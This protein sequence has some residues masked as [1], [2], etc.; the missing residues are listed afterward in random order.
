MIKKLDG[1][2]VDKLNT[3]VPLTEDNFNVLEGVVED[4]IAYASDFE[5]PYT[6]ESGKI[7]ASDGDGGAKWVNALNDEN[8]Y[9]KYDIDGKI[10]LLSDLKT[11]AKNNLVESINEIHNNITELD[12]TDSIIE[13]QNKA[14]KLSND[15]K[16]INSKLSSYVSESTFNT[17]INDINNKIDKNYNE[18][19]RKIND[20]DVNTDVS[21][22][23]GD[24]VTVNGKI[25]SLTNKI[26]D[27]E[28]SMNASGIDINII[29]GIGNYSVVQITD[30]DKKSTNDAMGACSSAFG[31]NNVSSGE[32]ASA[33]G[34]G[35]ISNGEYSFIVGQYNDPKEDTTSVFAIGNGTSSTNRKNLLTVSSS[36]VNIHSNKVSVDNEINS[37]LLTSEA[38]NVNNI[39]INNNNGISGQVLTSTGTGV[40]WSTVETST[41]IDLASL[42]G[43]KYNGGTGEIFNN[44]T[45]NKATGDCSHAEGSGTSAN[46]NYSHAGGNNSIAI[47]EGSFVH[48]INLVAGVS[49]KKDSGDY[50]ESTGNF[51]T[52]QTNNQFVVGKNNTSYDGMLFAV[53]NGDSYNSRSNIIDMDSNTIHIRRN[54]DIEGNITGKDINTINSNINA[55]NAEMYDL[56][57]NILKLPGEEGSSGESILDKII[58]AGSQADDALDKSN[59]N[60]ESIVNI[61]K[62]LATIKNNVNT[63]TTNITTNTRDISN[64]QK[65]VNTNTTNIKTNTNKISAL[66]TNIATNTTTIS[67]V[68]TLVVDTVQPAIVANT[69]NISKNATNIAT[70]KANI[71]TNSNNIATNAAA[72]KDIQDSMVTLEKGTGTNAFVQTAENASVKNI[73]SGINSMAL[74]CKSSAIGDY[75]VAVGRYGTAGYSS[76]VTGDH[77][78]ADMYSISSGEYNYSKSYSETSGAY[79]SACNYSNAEGYGTMAVYSPS[80]TIKSISNVTATTFNCSPTISIGFECI[81]YTAN[82]STTSTIV[83]PVIVKVTAVSGTTHTFTNISGGKISSSL[84]MVRYSSTAISNKKTTY[85]HAEGLSSMALGIASH[86][87]GFQ[88]TAA[89]E[90]SH[91]EGYNSS[92][93]A[94]CAH[95]GGRST[96]A[97]NDSMTA[98]GKYN[99]KNDTGLAGT[100][101]SSTIFSIGKGT[102]S[103]KANCFRVTLDG[104]SYG[105]THASSGADY[106]E[107]FE[108]LDGNPDNED[109][110][111]YF[112]T[113][114]GEMIR[115][116]NSADKYILGVVS[117][118]PS[119]IGDS[120][121]DEWQGKYE[122]DEFGR[123][124]YN[125]DSEE[126]TPKLSALF[127]EDTEYIARDL[128]PEWS[129]IGLLGKLYVRQDGTLEV[130]RFCS[131]NDEGIA[132]KADNGYYVMSVD[133]NVAKIIF[134]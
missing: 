35:N 99:T 82:T 34:N 33:F 113:L 52:L 18:L 5:L 85:A 32:F 100:S 27:L 17:A 94:A 115:K 10:G 76:F 97:Y 13:L 54:I 105:G 19:V 86:A 124:L 133:E 109:R 78:H 4:I 70:N 104:N 8:V 129:P 65:Q 56:K 88:T 96:T 43:Q 44:Y 28:S 90:A 81:L 48:G 108:W 6:R 36:N 25:D 51:G 132:T 93:T 59:S 61:N 24:L 131:I 9:T 60:A 69:N 134:K 106:A 21:T 107:M 126:H 128:R 123:I 40:K 73:A 58:A 119:V 41:E 2:S 95:A 74:G 114:D 1:K 53:G 57:Y 49:A 45:T 14:N 84:N 46:G 110:V 79:C 11:S 130:N 3:G 37:K 91:V 80:A 125:T 47:T 31:K 7:L 63:N 38:I 116:A 68:K 101:T 16:N 92:A 83:T 23:K 118:K 87:E 50:F 102:S 66:A 67:D 72:I 20:L 98:I 29:N 120:C 122:T 42:V 111:G 77:N 112:V 121:S 127:S 62:E 64:L 55:I 89:G 15:I 39:K 26:N 75:S 117:S 22:I 30:S 71:S 12:S 103:A